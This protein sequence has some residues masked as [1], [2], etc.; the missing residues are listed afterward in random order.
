MSADRERDETFK[1]LYIDRRLTMKQ[2]AE[3]YNVT[4]QCVQHRLKAMG[5]SRIS[6]RS[7]IDRRTLRRLYLQ[8][9]LSHREI[10]ERL[11][12]GKTMVARELR[13]HGLQRER[14][15]DREARLHSRSEIEELYISRGLSQQAIAARFGIQV[16]LLLKLLRRLGITYRHPKDRPRR[17]NIDDNDLRMLYV[18][19]R[20]T[21][22]AIAA[23]YGCSEYVIRTH[24]RKL[25]VTTTYRR[26]PR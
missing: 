10:G 17:Y 7:A 9:K 25:G 23:I 18:N 12:F 11:G 13:R 20:R 16:P 22:S 6:R 2:I 26:D 24:L 5:V 14:P 15:L 19:D 4:R 21:M 8:S 1:R 3:R